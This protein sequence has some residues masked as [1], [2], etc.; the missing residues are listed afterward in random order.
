MNEPDRGSPPEV[1]CVSTQRR[2]LLLGCG[3]RKRKFLSGTDIGPL[4]NPVTLDIDPATQPDV[5]HDLEVLPYPFPNDTFNEIWASHVLEHCGRQGDWRFFFAQWNEFWR[6]LKPGGRFFA[7]VPALH[8]PWV[9]GD[10]GHSRVIQPE[11][12]IF[13]QQKNYAGVGKS[14]MADYRHVYFADFTVLFENVDH[15][16]FIFVLEAIK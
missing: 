4:E 16:E 9:W 2:E 13:L 6:I 12:L 7:A 3:H 10:P 8:S 5:Q 11:T 14:T 15:E 1:T